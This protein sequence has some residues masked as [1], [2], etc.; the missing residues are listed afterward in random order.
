[1]SHQPTHRCRVVFRSLESAAFTLAELLAVITMIGLL[2]GLLLPAL[3]KA[4]ATV[5]HAHCV[6]HLRQWGLATQIYAHDHDDFLP[7]EGSPSPTLRMTN[8]GWYIALPRTLGLPVYSTQAWRTN[9]LARPEPNL[10]LCA[11]NPRRATN[12]NLFHYCL[13]SHVDGTGNDDRPTKLG[14]IARP[15]QTVW[16]FDNGKRAAVAQQNNVHTNIHSGGAQF[17]FL[18]GH[19]ARFHNTAYWDFKAARGRTNNPEIL[20]IP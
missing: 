17:L 4:K 20:W 6:N 18:D 16:L 14:W 8:T 19:V 5:Q 7:D 9:A 12:N 11:A 2:A 15:A 3:S 13:N 1:M 10:F